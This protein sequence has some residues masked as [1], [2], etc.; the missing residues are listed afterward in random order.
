MWFQMSILRL[1]LEN[2]DENW[3]KYVIDSCHCGGSNT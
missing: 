3:I 2:I 1:H